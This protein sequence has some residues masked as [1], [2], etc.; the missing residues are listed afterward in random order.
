MNIDN[1]KQDNNKITE[2]ENNN[3]NYEEYK[4]RGKVW[5]APKHIKL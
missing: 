3:A 5:L 4:E 1:Y 2:Q